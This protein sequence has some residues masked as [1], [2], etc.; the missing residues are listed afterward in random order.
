ML[1]AAAAAALLTLAHAALLGGGSTVQRPRR[2]GGGLQMNIFDQFTTNLKQLSDQRVARASHIMLKPADEDR[3]SAWESLKAWKEEI[4]S[5]DTTF[6][7]YAKE[8][9]VCSTKVK[10]GDLG[11]FTRGKLPRVSNEFD[12]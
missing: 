4:G 9:S 5:D 6:A 11:F 10:G 1:R 8:H 7:E 3:S 2:S 12:A